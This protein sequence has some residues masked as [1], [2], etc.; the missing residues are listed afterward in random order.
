M[1]RWENYLKSAVQILQQYGGD[2]PLHHFLKG[3]FKQNP[4]MGSRDRRWVSQLVYDYFRLGQWEQSANMEERIK[5]GVFLC[6][7][8]QNDF[9]NFHSPGLNEQISLPLEDKLPLVK[10]NGNGFSADALF[11]FTAE[12]S[13][14]IKGEEWAQ[15]MLKQPNLYIRARPG[16][17]D[18]LL[19]HLGLSDTAFVQIGEQTIQLPNGT[20][21]EKIFPQK[22][23]YEV[24]DLSSQQTGS[25]FKPKRAENWWD[26]CAASGGKSILLKDQMPSVNLLVSDVRAS[27]IQNLKSRF[28]EA[29]VGNYSA[30]VIDLTVDNFAHSLPRKQFDG[31]IL[32]APCS[33]SGTWGRTP[34][35]LAFFTAA[36]IKEYTDLQE[37]IAMNVLN[38]V[39]PGGAFIYI[40][41]SVFKAE[42]EDMVEKLVATGKLKQEEGGL[43]EGYEKGADTMYAV[44]FTKI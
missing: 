2:V 44:R 6:E 4:K 15:S 28:S 26:C 33:G 1:T 7:D 22:N 31:I 27:I 11:P 17:M 21:L 24:Q 23:W 3:F 12:L 30:Q 43:I 5:A 8:E 19:K 13:A 18:Q 16:K 25:L 10:L 14:G 39:R 42:N 41:C 37:K 40:T 9:L 36:K 20:N 32:D 29:S 38:Y 34:E 35:N